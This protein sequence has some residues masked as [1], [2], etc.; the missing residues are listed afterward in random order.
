MTASTSTILFTLSGSYSVTL[1]VYC[2]VFRNSHLHG[3]GGN[4][5]VRCALPLF[6]ASVGMFHEVKQIFCCLH[7]ARVCIMFSLSVD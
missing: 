6:D 5:Y 2:S 4:H 1:S 3:I 7:T